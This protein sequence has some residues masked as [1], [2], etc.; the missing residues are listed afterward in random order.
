MRLWWLTHCRFHVNLT[1]HS[2]THYSRPSSMTVGDSMTTSFF[3]TVP[4]LVTSPSAECSYNH[5]TLLSSIVFCV[6]LG[7]V[8]HLHCPPRLSVPRDRRQYNVGNELTRNY[9]IVT[10]YKHGH[11][12][13]KCYN[14]INPW[15]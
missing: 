14:Y 15:P 5:S 9:Y 3:S 1:D 7:D 8:N 6:F 11:V 10:S 4:C 2:L 12:G 13:Y